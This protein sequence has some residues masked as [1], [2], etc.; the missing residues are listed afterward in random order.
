MN[1]SGLRAVVTPAGLRHC[2]P[3]FKSLARFVE[4]EGSNEIS[5]SATYKKGPPFGDPFLYVA[6]VA[7]SVGIVSKNSLITG[8]L[9]GT[10]SCWGLFLTYY[11][12][13]PPVFIGVLSKSTGSISF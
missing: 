6:M 8:N 12:P 7:V 2:V 4:Q 11:L 5:L 13:Y 9:Q 3:R 1:R 10:L